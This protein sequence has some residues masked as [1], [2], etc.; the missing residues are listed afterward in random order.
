MHAAQC[1]S[2]HHRVAVA[3]FLVWLRAALNRENAET[4]SKR[5]WRLC[6][7][8]ALDIVTLRCGTVNDGV[9]QYS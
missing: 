4:G 7:N 2:H 1:R 8:Y 6:Q 9:M 3:G 5:P